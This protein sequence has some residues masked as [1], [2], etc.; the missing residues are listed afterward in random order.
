LASKLGINAK[1]VEAALQLLE[2]EGLLVGQGAGLA[3]G[4]TD[5]GGRLG[6]GLRLE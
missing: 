4:G 2:Q 1:T 3:D 5:Q 6:G